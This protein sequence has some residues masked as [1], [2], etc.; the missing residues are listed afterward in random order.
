MFQFD[1][2]TYG[3]TIRTYGSDVLTIDG[4]VSHAVD[5]V[6]H[7]VKISDY[8]TNADTD[9]KARAWI[10]A[11]D[12][13]NATLR[14]QWIR[15]VVRY[16]NGCQE[17][18]SCWSAR[19]RTYNDGLSQVLVDTNGP[20]FWHAGTTCPGGSG[21]AVGAIEAKLHAL[22]GCG[23]FLGAPT[24][25]EQGTPDGVGRYNVFQNG[26]IYWTPQ[27]GAFEVHGVIRDTW[28]SLGW[29]AGS[30]GYP[31][32]DEY[33]VASGR[34]SDFQHGAITFDATSGKAT[35]TSTP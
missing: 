24:T 10:N 5:Y 21:A 33:A 34:R 19:Y 22:G 6:T 2:G 26:S 17:G 29:E 11:F 31:V 15:T 3:D 35:A 27:T 18:W 1:S 8:T 16:Y 12:L 7:M 9:E 14:D 23:S 30:L 13:H 28:A 4:Q 25:S 32:S 20:G